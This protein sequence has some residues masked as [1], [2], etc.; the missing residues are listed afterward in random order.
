MDDDDD[1]NVED[2]DDDGGWLEAAGGRDDVNPGVDRLRCSALFKANPPQPQLLLLCRHYTVKNST[3]FTSPPTLAEHRHCVA[4]HCAICIWLFCTATTAVHCSTLRAR[5]RSRRR[6]RRR[7]KGAEKR[8]SRR[9]E[10]EKEQK[11]EQ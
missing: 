5:K 7:E 11:K 2:D 6:G 3:I 1:D 4:L 8:G 9:W 10:Q